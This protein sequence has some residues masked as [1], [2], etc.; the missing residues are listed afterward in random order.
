MALKVIN[1][2]NSRLRF[3]YRKNRYLSPYLKRLLG[4]AVIQPHFDYACSACYPNLNKKFKSILQTIQ[5]KCMRFCLQL[6]SRSH[7]GIKEFEQIN[8]LPVSETFNQ[9]ICFNLLRLLMR[10]VLYIYMIYIN[11][12]DK[13]K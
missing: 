4:N 2:I 7:I 8:C 9:C 6:D 10:I 13:I 3:L 5:N 12:L 1:K 11:H